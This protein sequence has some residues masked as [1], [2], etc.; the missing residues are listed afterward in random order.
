VVRSLLEPEDC[1]IELALV[2]KH[3]GNT[4]DRVLTKG[5]RYFGLGL[6]GISSILY[7]TQMPEKFEFDWLLVLCCADDF[8]PIIYLQSANVH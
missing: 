2:G 3:L 8:S 7:S 1:L 4:P 5:P 6:G